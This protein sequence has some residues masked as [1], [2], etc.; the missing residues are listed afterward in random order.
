MMADNIYTSNMSSVL[1]KSKFTIHRFHPGHLCVL[2]AIKSKQ[3][4]RRREWQSKIGAG[5]VVPPTFNN[6]LFQEL[7][8]SSRINF[9][10]SGASSEHQLMCVWRPSAVKGLHLATSSGLMAT[11]GS[12]EYVRQRTVPE[13]FLLPSKL[14]LTFQRY[15]KSFTAQRIFKALL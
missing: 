4:S 13:H 1:F 8:R 3:W 10:G 6:S 2:F 14:P 11:A 5:Q 15:I 12:L 7:K 9:P